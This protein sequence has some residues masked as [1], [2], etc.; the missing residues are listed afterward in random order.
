MRLPTLIRIQLRVPLYRCLVSGWTCVKHLGDI[1]IGACLGMVQQAFGWSEYLVLCTGGSGDLQ[2]KTRV[3]ASSQTG[4]PSASRFHRLGRF[5]YWL[6]HS[7]WLLPDVWHSL[8]QGWKCSHGVCRLERF[9][10]ESIL[11]AELR[12][13]PQLSHRISALYRRAYSLPFS[14]LVPGREP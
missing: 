11:D 10:S 4:P 8:A 6:L 13:G 1:P 7:G 2:A 9:R 12:C 14:F 5:L 3:C